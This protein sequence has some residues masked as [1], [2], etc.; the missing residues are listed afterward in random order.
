MIGIRPLRELRWKHGGAA[1]PLGFLEES[2]G[3]FGIGKFAI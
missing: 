1:L 2:I 3:A